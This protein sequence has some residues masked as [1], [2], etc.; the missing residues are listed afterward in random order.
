MTELSYLFING[1]ISVR[2]SALPLRWSLAPLVEQFYVFLL[3]VAE[4]AFKEANVELVT[5][6]NYEAVLEAAKETGYITEE[7]MPTLQEW[8]ANPSEWRN[9]LK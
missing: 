7:V 4:K 6:T 5:L 2:K 3:D 1:L 8:R 9:D